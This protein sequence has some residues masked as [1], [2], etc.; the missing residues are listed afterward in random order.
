MLLPLLPNDC[1]NVG[2]LLTLRV[3]PA[4]NVRLPAAGGSSL[5]QVPDILD[6]GNYADIGFLPGTAG[7]EEPPAEDTGQGE[8]YKP[9]LQLVVARDSPQLA[10]AVARLSQVRYVVAAYEDGNGLVK[11]VGTP[12]HPLRF[13]GGLET[14]KRAA[15]RNGY[16][17]TFAGLV[18]TRAPF[19]PGLSL[20]GATHQAFSFG[21]SFGFR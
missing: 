11:L 13:A 17:L 4:A 7:F 2:G 1:P 8:S 12:Q 5:A 20:E 14:G 21:F 6:P 16:P 3:W 15:D 19:C 10:E 9:L 18:P